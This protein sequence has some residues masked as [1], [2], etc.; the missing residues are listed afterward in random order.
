[1]LY[2]QE[3][4]IETVKEAEGRGG[5][6]GT[7]YHP[8]ESAEGGAP[9]IGYGHK[10]N[11][12]VVTIDGE[13]VDLMTTPLNEDM[14]KALLE[15]DL[16]VAE[17]KARKEYTAANNPAGKKWSELSNVE[18]SIYTEIVFHVGTLS[19]REGKFG[20]PKLSKAIKD[21]DQK[22][23]LQEIERGFRPA[24]SDELKPDKRRNKL[25]KKAYKEQMKSTQITAE[26]LKK[27]MSSEAVGKMSQQDKAKL[28][29][30]LYTKMK[31][32]VQET[33]EK[34][35]KE[36]ID[37]ITFQNDKEVEE[38]APTEPKE[39]EPTQE[40][41][42]LFERDGKIFERFEGKEIEVAEVSRDETN[43]SINAS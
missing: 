7:Y 27:F 28:F 3:W 40:E 32:G 24:G 15:Q 20:W 6:D 22:A 29:I 39:T 14:A 35:S 23:I 19:N 9:T 33:G 41:S 10:I 26:N 12:R 37:R 34:V 11:E 43:T 18:K 21:K 38:A 2:K 5:Y 42:V 25:L 1:M 17:V 13:E 4:L 8:Y 31:Q 16:Q 36:V 30:A